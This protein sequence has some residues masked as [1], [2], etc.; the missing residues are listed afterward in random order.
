MQAPPDL[1]L[2]A[3]ANSA[4]YLRMQLPSDF[5]S[6]MHA[7]LGADYDPFLESYNRPEQIGL[8]ANLLKVDAQSLKSRLPWMLE[9]LP[10]L[11]GGFLV[12]IGSD[13]AVA[14]PG[15]HPYHNAGVYYL[16]E[17][18]AMAVGPALVL[19]APLQDEERILDLCAAPGGKSTQLAGLMDGK[20]VLV[21]NEIHPRRVWELAEN[22]ERWGARNAIVLNE[23]SAR[24]AAKL[25]GFFDRVLVDAPC[26]GE[27]MFRKSEAARRDWSPEAVR[28]CA[29]RQLS[30]LDDAMQLLHP[31]GILIYST[32]TFNP[33]ENESVVAAVLD[34]WPGCTLASLDALPGGSRGRPEWAGGPPELSLASRL[35]PHQA[36][37]EGHFIAALIKGGERR[38]PKQPPDHGNKTPQSGTAVYH[39]FVKNN[40][41]IDPL[42][43]SS[44]EIRS[45]GSRVYAVPVG[46]P[47]L[48]ALKVIH[49]GWWLGSVRTGELGRVRFE[50]AH[51]LALGLVRSHARQ[52]QAYSPED[53][54]VSAYLRGET[55]L[56]PG[57]DG[58]VL[59]CVDKFPLGWGKRSRG[60]LKN[61]Y[62]KGLRVL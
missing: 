5:L 57:D 6:R 31:G 41:S 13:P 45:V 4:V 29:L 43:N 9:E 21:A 59:I 40:M 18:S 7:L 33:E 53:W 11:E 26:S 8:R 61:A 47:D 17:P 32:C 16:Q 52:V 36:P 54:Q 27:G 2:V 3:G 60:V 19:A 28:A 39:E 34:R 62:P 15:K 48:S 24:L 51:S 44:V 12:D 42:A 56:A 55:L 20:G 23:T 10:W 38:S 58:W 14:A 46:S 30:I 22:L 50:P 25:P 49:P 1:S 37:G 35:W